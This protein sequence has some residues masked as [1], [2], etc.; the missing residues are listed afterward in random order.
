MAK[1]YEISR[2][3]ITQA[4]KMGFD[5]PIL[6]KI[7]KMLINSEELRS[8]NLI[9]LEDRKFEEYTFTI[10]NGVVC[11]I[12]LNKTVKPF[13]TVTHYKCEDC[14]DIRKVNVFEDCMHCDNGVMSD[15]TE[16]GYCFGKGGVDKLIPCQTCS[17]K[18]RKIY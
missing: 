7:K 8:D 3:V 16:C 12:K 13:V 1:K 10:C 4:K 14:K 6:P 9:K 2:V 18:H 11:N 15:K 5:E 17:G